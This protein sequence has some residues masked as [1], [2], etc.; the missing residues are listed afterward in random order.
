[1][2]CFPYDYYMNFHFT[3]NNSRITTSLFHRIVVNKSTYIGL[4]IFRVTND[5]A[6]RRSEISFVLIDALRRYF[7]AIAI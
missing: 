2:M 7:S 5:D 1:M 6:F 3:N 4:D